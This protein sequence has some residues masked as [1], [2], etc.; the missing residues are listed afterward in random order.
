MIHL[1]TVV[2]HKEVFMDYFDVNTF[3]S[4]LTK[5]LEGKYKIED[6]AKD[7]EQ[8]KY[9]LVGSPSDFV[10][11]TFVN[12]DDKVSIALEFSIYAN[13][14]FIHTVTELIEKLPK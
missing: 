1:N 12:I 14:T 13:D 11:L 9:K 7:G 3:L 6:R 8:L 5:A 4:N 2:I 10:Y